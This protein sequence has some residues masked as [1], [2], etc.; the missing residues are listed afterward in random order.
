MIE[1]NLCV[2]CDKPA[3]NCENCKLKRNVTQQEIWKKAVLS[4][5]TTLSELYNR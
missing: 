2:N 5:L 3:G 4:E 1:E